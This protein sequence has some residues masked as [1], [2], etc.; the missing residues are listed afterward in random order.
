MLPAHV[1]ARFGYL[2][3]LK[4]L[5]AAGADV[6]RASSSDGRTALHFAASAGQEGAVSWLLEEASADPDA[7]TLLHDDIGTE[8]S[9]HMA[10]YFG[11]APVVARLLR[12]GANPNATLRN[13]RTPALIAAEMGWHD[14]LHTLVTCSVQYPVDLS[15]C[16]DSGKSPLYCAVERACA[17]GEG[18]GGEATVKLLLQAGADAAQATRRNKIPLAAAAE[19]GALPVAKVLL[20]HEA[21]AHS[22]VH[23]PLS[24]SSFS[25]VALGLAQRTNNK[26]MRDLLLAYTLS[27]RG[28]ARALL[29]L[30]YEVEEGEGEEGEEEAPPFPTP[31]LRAYERPEGLSSGAYHAA[32]NPLAGVFGS[33]A[34]GP[35]GTGASTFVAALARQAA[36]G[37]GSEADAPPAPVVMGRTLAESMIAMRATREREAAEAAVRGAEME[38][39]HRAKATEMAASARRRKEE[40]AVEEAATAAQN[41]VAAREKADREA[42]ARIE[43]ERSLLAGFLTRSAVVKEAGPPP[44]PV[45]LSGA[46][47]GPSRAAITASLVALSLGPAS[48]APPPP[49]KQAPSPYAEKLTAAARKAAKHGRGS[50]GKGPAVRAIDLLGEGASLLPSADSTSIGAVGKPAAAAAR[51]EPPSSPRTA[52]AGNVI[53]AGRAAPPERVAMTLKSASFAF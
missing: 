24:R 3:L 34:A 51:E 53:G 40:K 38:R 27:E 26:A 14:V 11:H 52:P 31:G 33:N 46:G 32:H 22:A 7:A 8:A 48:S 37:G 23:L 12:A 9:I 44:L 47:I 1:A 25:G 39:T 21:A 6:G 42:N 29:G 2:P 20:D 15:V 43:R 5:Q 28:R 41:A 13:G 45:S 10:T 19:K 16:T 17:G 49:V 50:P 30:G 36:H 4:L 35:S 18:G